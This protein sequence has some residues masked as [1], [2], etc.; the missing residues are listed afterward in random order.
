MTVLV[1]AASRHGATHE[2]AAAIGRGLAVRGLGVEVV[3]TEELDPSTLEDYEAFV[4]GSATYVGRWLEPAA[5]LVE[6]HADL[7]AVRPVWLFSSGPVGEPLR[8]H[9]DRAVDVAPYLEATGARGHRIFAGKLDRDALGFGEK[10][11]VLAFHAQEGDFRDWV[12][13]DAFAVEIA[14]E[15]SALAVA[16]GSSTRR[17]GVASS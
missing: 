4:V 5:E 11:V 10:A 17:R 15:L 2:I 7:L 12:A 13:I 8:P 1:T 16:P 9:A 3:P 6:R 14:E